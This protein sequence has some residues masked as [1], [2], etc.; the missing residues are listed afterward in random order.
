MPG[1]REDHEA[2]IVLAAGERL[3]F[4]GLT[5]RAGDSPEET[6]RTGVSAATF[7]AVLAKL[8]RSRLALSVLPC[9]VTR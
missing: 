4:E 2:F 1:N 3:A 6:I 8:D 5:G 9:R 7:F